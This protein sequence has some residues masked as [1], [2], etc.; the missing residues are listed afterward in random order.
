MAILL[1]ISKTLLWNIYMREIQ[2]LNQFPAES[3]KNATDIHL[4]ISQQF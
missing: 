1:K 3:L 2:L 4:C